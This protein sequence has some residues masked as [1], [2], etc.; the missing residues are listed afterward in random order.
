MCYLLNNISLNSIVK[1]LSK[2]N[3]IERFANFLQYSL[4]EYQWQ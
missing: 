4:E 1:L 2:K 3:R